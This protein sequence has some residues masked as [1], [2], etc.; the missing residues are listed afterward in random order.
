MIPHF[1][2]GSFASFGDFPVCLRSA[3]HALVKRWWRPAVLIYSRRYREGFFRRW[4]SAGEDQRFWYSVEDTEKGSSGAG[5]ALVNTSGFDLQSYIQNG[6]LWA[7]MRRWLD[8]G[9][10]WYSSGSPAQNQRCYWE[11]SGQTAR[12]ALDCRSSA[13]VVFDFPINT[14][15]VFFWTL[16]LLG[17]V[18]LNQ[19]IISQSQMFIDHQISWSQL[20]DDCIIH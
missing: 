7:L 12:W 1:R 18:S 5:Q 2:L 13:S 17:L 19:H 9:R 3:G 14:L 6:V 4:S 16:S 20:M 8:A 15:F 11:G 10:R